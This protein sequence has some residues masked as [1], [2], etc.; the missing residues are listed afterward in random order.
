[1]LIRPKRLA[2]GLAVAASFAAAGRADAQMEQGSWSVSPRAGYLQWMR[3][4]GFENSA[5]VGLDAMYHIN[6]MF[7]I[8]PSLSVA[9]P[10]T[11]GEDFVTALRFGIPTAGDTT[12]YYEVVQPVTVLNAAVNGSRQLPLDRVS[13]YVTVGGG[14]YTLF[15]N[16]GV[17]R[18]SKTFSGPSANVGGGINIP[19]G[20]R[21]GTLFDVRDQILFNYDRDQLT[22][23]D[24][25]FLEG[26]FA[27]EFPPPPEKK[28]TLHNMAYSIGFS[29]SPRRATP[30]GAAEPT[31]TPAPTPAQ[32]QT[33]PPGDAR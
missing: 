22:P 12:L 6:S 1:M 18:A 27:P 21:A 23:T 25:R 29:F 24:A 28:E 11:R 7:G 15:L 19:L 2:L 9:R 30:E 33:P 14:L 5:A 13:P 17:N 10:N 3:E 16:P 8:G 20:A 4:S 31:A 26:R 32:P